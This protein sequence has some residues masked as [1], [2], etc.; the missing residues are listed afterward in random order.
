MCI[1]LLIQKLPS[2][3]IRKRLSSSALL[4][5]TGWVIGKTRERR[6][7]LLLTDLHLIKCH[8][9]TSSFFLAIPLQSPIIYKECEHISSRGQFPQFHLKSPDLGKK[10]Y[11][12]HSLAS[13]RLLSL[14]IITKETSLKQLL[15]H[16]S[17]LGM[18]AARVLMRRNGTCQEIRNCCDIRIPP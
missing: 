13:P 17:A 14:E 6:D 16:G 2:I 11:T 1:H 15:L 8:S 18:L 5:Q 7:P 9:L 10:S 4:E 12:V 3:I